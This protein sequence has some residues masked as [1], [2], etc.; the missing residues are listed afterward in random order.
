V[1]AT[2]VAGKTGIALCGTKSEATGIAAWAAGAKRDIGYTIEEGFSSF[3]EA[4]LPCIEVGNGGFAQAEFADA[5][6]FHNAA[7]LWRNRKTFMVLSYVSYCSFIAVKHISQP[8]GP[9]MTGHGPQVPALAVGQNSKQLI[10]TQLGVKVLLPFS[11]KMMP[12]L[13]CS[14]ILPVKCA[15]VVLCTMSLLSFFLFITQPVWC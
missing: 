15:T 3:Y 5:L 7:V 9:V 10:I 14:C 1:Q 12:P 2:I 11:S 6:L 8:E 4:L 13:N